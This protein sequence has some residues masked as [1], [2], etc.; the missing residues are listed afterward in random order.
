MIKKQRDLLGETFV[1]RERKSTDNDR[2]GTLESSERKLATETE[3]FRAFVER[4]A[5][6]AS[7]SGPVASA[8]SELAAARD[9]MNEAVE[10]L[11]QRRLA[12]AFDNE[13][14]ALTHLLK[15]RLSMNRI[16]KQ[17]QGSGQSESQQFTRAL[18]QALRP[19]KRQGDDREQESSLGELAREAAALSREEKKIGEELAGEM[20][21]GSQDAQGPKPGSASAGL[22]QPGQGAGGGQGP[23]DSQKPGQRPGDSPLERLAGR[24]APSDSG[25]QDRPGAKVPYRIKGGAL[26]D[27]AD[28]QEQAVEKGDSV[29]KRLARHRRASELA[30]RRMEDAHR[31]MR[32]AEENLKARERETSKLSLKSAEKTLKRLADHLKGLSPG[33]MPN[34][35]DNF[36]RTAQGAAQG[37]ASC[38]GG[39]SSSGGGGQPGRQAGGRSP[40]GASGQREDIAQDAET[41]EDWLKA[42]RADAREENPDLTQRLEALGDRFNLERLADDVRRANRSAEQA[43]AQ[44][45]Q[46]LD[47]DLEARFR[48]LADAMDIEKRRLVQG[49]LERLLAAE[50]EAAALKKEITQAGG[51][52]QT[53]NNAGGSQPQSGGPGGMGARVEDLA[54][55]LEAI[56]DSTINKLAEKMMVRIRNP[57]GPRSGGGPPTTRRGVPLAVAEEYLGPIVV[58]LHELI[59][60]V[61]RQEVLA[62]RD[63]RVPDRYRRLV[64]RYYK[65]LSDDLR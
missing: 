46:K 51:A 31:D 30:K 32:R 52:Q 50:A 53:G 58:R 7:S 1:L 55:E 42:M 14:T 35:M 62:A 3:E 26:G 57:W 27:L 54:N 20:P 13:E 2:I 18:R 49:L 45:T 61:I 25:D 8:P 56:E 48:G 47:Q 33:N 64:E 21:A 12:A 40:G 4:R 60:E 29:L 5:R 10:D 41:L 24:D 23:G 37:C 22:G 43:N 34:R 59:A 16:L 44:R 39:Q 15:A 17:M 6:S 38:A 36:R 65:A 63:D 19:P 28:R 11:A 9:S